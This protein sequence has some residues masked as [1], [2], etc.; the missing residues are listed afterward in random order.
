MVAAEFV[1]DPKR[2]QADASYLPAPPPVDSSGREALGMEA[3]PM[4]ELTMRLNA[5][6]SGDRMRG[7]GRRRPGYSSSQGTLSPVSEVDTNEA[8]SGPQSHRLPETDQ[9]FEEARMPSMRP[10]DPRNAPS[11]YHRRPAPPSLRQGPS[12]SVPRQH[13]RPTTPNHLNRGTPATHVRHDRKDLDDFRQQMRL[14]RQD[15]LRV[16]Q[17]ARAERQRSV[18]FR[19]THGQQQGMPANLPPGVP[20]AVPTHLHG[21]PQR[22]HANLPPI[23]PPGVPPLPPGSGAGRRPSGRARAYET[24]TL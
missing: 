7:T 22:V 10:V 6:P 1:E 2:R 15:S 18:A 3:L 5:L 21:R 12:S 17:Q 19:S 14:E 9:R 4:E 20:P 23:L 16:L 8:T 11:T 13:S 24:G